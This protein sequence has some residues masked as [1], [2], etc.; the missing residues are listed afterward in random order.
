[1]TYRQ[2]PARVFFIFLLGLIWSIPAKAQQ[3]RWFQPQSSDLRE[4]LD[5]FDAEQ[6]ASSQVFLN[7]WMKRHASF[8]NQEGEGD[9]AIAYYYDAFC[10]AESETSDAVSQLKRAINRYP[11]HFLSDKARYYWLKSEFKARKWEAVNDFPTIASEVL[12]EKQNS[13]LGAMRLVALVQKARYQEAVTQWGDLRDP[14][15]EMD[16]MASY[17]AGYASFK[18][19]RYAKVPDYLIPVTGSKQY[20]IS[21]S[22][23]LAQLFF[24]QKEYDKVILATQPSADKKDQKQRESFALVTAQAFFMKHNYEKA[25]PYFKIY[26]EKTA[27]PGNIESF[28]AGFSAWKNNQFKEAITLLNKPVA[29]QDSLAQM[30]AYVSAE[31]HLSLQEKDKAQK[32]F[33]LSSGFSYNKAIRELSAFNSAKLLQ[34]LG[35]QA[36]ALSGLQQF[37]QLF[38]KSK[39]GDEVRNMI[40]KLLLSSRN[41]RQAAEVLDSVEDKTVENRK[42]FQQVTFYRGVELF[43]E[44]DY[45]QALSFFKKSLEHPYEN[46]IRLMATF[47][48]GE[49]AYKLNQYSEA[50]AFHRS[51]IEMSGKEEL[52]VSVNELS[53]R[54]TAGYVHYL[55]KNYA[56]AFKEWELGFDLVQKSPLRYN[57]NEDYKILIP[58]MIAR[59]ADAAF[60]LAD[61]PKALLFYD[62]VI[63]RN[64]PGTDYALYQKATIHGLRAENTRKI[65]LLKRLN[66]LF[67]QSAYADNALMDLSN[68]YVAMDQPQEALIQLDKLITGRPNSN[69]I[70]Q[71]YNLKGLIY[72][73][74]DQDEKALEAYRKTVSLAPKSAEARDAIAG[75]K[76]IYVSKNEVDQFYDFLKTVPSASFTTSEVDSVSF[77]AALKLSQ[78]GDCNRTIKELSKY[79]TKFPDGYFALQAHQMRAECHEKVKDTLKAIEDFQY[80]SQQPVNSYSEKSLLKLMAFKRSIKDS[81]GSIEAAEKLLLSSENK[82]AQLEASLNLMELNFGLQQKSKSQQ[83]ALKVLGYDIATTEAKQSASLILGQLAL[84]NADYPQAMIEFTKVYEAQKN[85]KAAEAR[86]LMAKTHFM[87]KEWSTAQSVIFDLAAKMPYFDEWVARSFILLARVYNEQGNSTQAIATLKSVIDNHDGP[88][89]IAE[90]KQLLEQIKKPATQLQED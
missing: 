60:A 10:S 6:Y 79:L 42:V 90:A 9:W 13:E 67:P 43:N 33:E 83:F 69:Y 73:N 22:L 7:R 86:Y 66:T 40:G 59:T 84:E 46:K 35:L 39:M 34:E 19:E 49:S 3:N 89:V 21:A 80:V 41:F 55:A 54:Y 76:A 71:A 17:F 30:A 68:T 75:I 20:G 11:S 8:N 29:K 58:D 18:L 12:D 14:Q 32:A 64:A 85:I 53:C 61:Y 36:Q 57:Q 81:T 37:L 48:A 87:R 44:N 78:S 51:F 82:A 70:R 47:W 88:K 25:W 16:E 28:Q 45:S 4:G 38:P 26:L 50:L 62:R 5:L 31:C 63:N 23:L 77:E 27:K 2:L 52:P 65:E 72:Y 1:M 24:S 74:S 15:S 56:A